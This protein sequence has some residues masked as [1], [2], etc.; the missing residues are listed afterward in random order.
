MNSRSFI[1]QSHIQNHKQFQNFANKKKQKPSIGI[2]NSAIDIFI[3]LKKIEEILG[4]Q[5][6]R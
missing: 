1:S 2:R 3:F 5:T 6:E 4:K